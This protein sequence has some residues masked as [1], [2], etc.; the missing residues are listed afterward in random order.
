MRVQ[1]ALESV[2]EEAAGL[3]ETE[4]LIMTHE[5]SSITPTDKGTGSYFAVTASPAAVVVVAAA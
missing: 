2:E 5:T 1:E 4:L 3:V